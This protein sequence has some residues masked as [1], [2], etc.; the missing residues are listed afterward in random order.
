MA[1]I[2][3]LDT[4][5][6]ESLVM[7]ARQ[8]EAPVCRR[9]EVQK[10]HGQLINRHIAEVMDAAKLSWSHLEAVCVL[11][12]PGSY[13]GLRI[14]LGT[15]KGICYAQDLPLVLLNKLQLIFHHSRPDQRAAQNGV[16]LKARTEEYFFA[17]Y[18]AD[19]E[20]LVAP[21]LSTSSQLQ[22][23]CEAQTLKLFSIDREIGSELGAIEFLDLQADI[24]ADYCFK[25]CEARQYAD[26]F[27]S[28]PFYLKN[29][30]VNKINNL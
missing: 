4:S 14:S 18:Q 29:V 11:N 9:N 17:S 28:E 5:D 24:L 2:L 8:G 30:Y 20:E 13:T 1:A 3:Y 12:G 10:D 7:L 16:L 22:A 19:G 23:L 26:L 6:R 25:A 15:A 27:L 21:G